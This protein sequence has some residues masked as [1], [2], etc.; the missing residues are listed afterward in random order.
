MFEYDISDL[1]NDPD[2]FKKAHARHEMFEYHDVS[3]QR[4]S[5][6]TRLL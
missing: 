4:V 2:I 3:P 6:V 5:F 1:A